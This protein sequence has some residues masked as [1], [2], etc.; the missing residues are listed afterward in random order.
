LPARKLLHTV[1]SYLYIITVLLLSNSR[2][3]A[4][5]SVVHKIF[6]ERRQTAN[7][8]IARDIYT[9]MTGESVRMGC[10]QVENEQDVQRDNEFI[11]DFDMKRTLEN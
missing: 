7:A 1:Y 4:F 3:F 6:T 5:R 10:W 11:F 2:E 8:G 9:G